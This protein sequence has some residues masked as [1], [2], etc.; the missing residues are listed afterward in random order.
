MLLKKLYSNL[1]LFKDVVFKEGLNFIVGE[2]TNP[3]V[4]DTKDSYNGVGKS[5]IIELIHFCLGSS[6]IRTFSDKMEDAIFYLDFEVENKVHSIKREC[7][8]S[9][10]AYLDDIE[11]KKITDFTNKLESIIFPNIPNLSGLSFRSLISRFIRR[12]KSSYNKYYEYI[13]KEK[14]YNQT[15]INSYLLGLNVDIAQEKM[16]IKEDSKVLTDAKKSLKNDKLLNEYF[17]GGKDIKFRMADLKEKVSELEKKLEGFK[18]AENYND[19]KKE[20]DEAVRQKNDLLNEKFLLN[21]RIKKAKESLTNNISLTDDDVIRLYDEAK[22]VLPDNVKKSLS[23]V[24]Q[25]HNQLLKNRSNTLNNQIEK[26]DKRLSEVESQLTVLNNKINDN[27]KF[28]KE[29][30]ALN[31]YVVLSQTYSNTKLQLE[32]LQDYNKL[33]S[34]YE[35]ELS[36]KKKQKEDNK[37]LI[38]KYLDESIIIQDKLMT[39][40]KFYAKQFYENKTSGLSIN[41]N[42]NNNQ[43]AWNIH[44]DIE[45][46][47][48]DGINEVLIFCF[49]FTMF[50]IGKH[51]IQFLFHDSRL[52][53]NMDPRQRY[54][55]IKIAEKY[56][57]N[58]NVQ[59]I[60]S[61]NED[62]INSIE[63]MVSSEQFSGL[64][65][66]LENNTILTLRDDKPENKLLGMK[67][68]LPY[69]K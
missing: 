3:K 31:E 18:V 10:I 6:K 53:S 65:D 21:S 50:S 59:Y 1:P 33:I 36:L 60:S 17:K 39:R 30:G 7:K 22:T 45:G 13:K 63:P 56:C 16:K 32:K 57:M 38:K 62:M 26:F 48:S 61:W 58:N 69:D 14:P 52:F 5:L 27:M 19:V 42:Y 55:A 68:D 64:K 23:E 29:H 28:L 66:I 35:V 8:G 25:F 41:G 20:A 11:Y 40:F 2:R 24:T 12:S 54:S 49:D 44:A 4:K 51:N 15:L 67:I 9:Q 37:I 43:I 34:D 47:S 46:D